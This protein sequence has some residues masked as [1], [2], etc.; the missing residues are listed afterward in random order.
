MGSRPC[1]DAGVDMTDAEERVGAR[2]FV[3]EGVGDACVGNGT[4]A[5]DFAAKGGG[6]DLMEENDFALTPGVRMIVSGIT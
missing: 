2:A 4:R 6:G 3:A 1:E 5:A